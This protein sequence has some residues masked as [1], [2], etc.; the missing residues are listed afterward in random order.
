MEPENDKKKKKRA[1][2]KLKRRKSSSRETEKCLV[3][4]TSAP[5]IAT[6]LS[7]QTTVVTTDGHRRGTT[8]SRA[9]SMP[10]ET[11]ATDEHDHGKKSQKPTEHTT[12]KQ[13]KRPSSLQSQRTPISSL[14]GSDETKTVTNDAAKISDKSTI[15]STTTY[16]DD[17]DP[18]WSEME[19]Y[20]E[21]RNGLSEKVTTSI[22]EDTPTTLPRILNPS[23]YKKHR[24]GI[25]N[26][27]ID[28]ECK[29][30]DRQQCLVCLTS[31]TTINVTTIMTITAITDYLVLDNNAKKPVYRQIEICDDCQFRR[32][33]MRPDIVLPLESLG[34][35]KPLYL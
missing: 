35:F 25:L 11:R 18:D 32:N 27:R 26:E 30:G 21:K 13:S 31:S 4:S 29:V 33:L 15:F 34:F 24:N 2:L 3:T 12:K 10:W 20:Y 5:L 8:L 9:P 17:D 16:A 6:T 14:C 7:L 1:T 19:R 28:E 22:K 23:S